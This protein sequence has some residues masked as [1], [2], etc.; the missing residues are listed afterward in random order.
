MGRSQVLDFSADDYFSGT[1]NIEPIRPTRTNWLRIFE[2]ALDDLVHLVVSE[3]IIYCEGKDRP[4]SGNVERG[5]DAKVYTTI[6]GETH[7][8]TVF[9]SSGGNTELDQRSDIAIQILSKVFGELEI[10]VLKDRD[11]ASGR[12]T[13][14]AE[15]QTYLSNNPTNHRVLT[16]W[17]IE[18]YLFEKEVLAA[19]CAK[20][21]LTFD[22]AAYD[23]FVTDIANQNLKDSTAHIRNFCGIT[24][25]INNEVFKLNLADCLTSETA[26]YADLEACIF[27]QTAEA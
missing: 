8:E 9:V 7:P 1:K 22:E 13:T 25:S 10:L 20:E 19:Y 4:G 21:G 23:A 16:R 2:T 24:T 3:R 15:R 26:V 18:N 12:L 17:E 27:S 5:F 14:E 11:M 6:F